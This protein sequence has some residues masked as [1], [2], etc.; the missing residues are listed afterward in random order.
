M[1]IGATS[2]N[3]LSRCGSCGRAEAAPEPAAEPSAEAGNRE[4]SSRVSRDCCGGA[5]VEVESEEEA[6]E[7]EVEAEEEGVVCNKPCKIYTETMKKDN[8]WRSKD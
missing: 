6:A 5:V 7:V 3:A 4:L 2:C 1:R 8:R